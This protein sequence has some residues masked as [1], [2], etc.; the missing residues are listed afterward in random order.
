[1]DSFATK[2]DGF[3]CSRDIFCRLSDPS[4]M[5]TI[6]RIHNTRQ[7]KMVR[8][9]SL[10]HQQSKSCVDDFFTVSVSKITKFQW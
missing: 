1:M 4:P 8:L 9:E 6:F 10:I 5:F 3:L 2:C 7:I